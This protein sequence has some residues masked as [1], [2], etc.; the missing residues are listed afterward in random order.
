MLKV[1]TTCN[2]PIKISLKQE[3]FSENYP[4][5]DTK[6]TVKKPEEKNTYEAAV[7]APIPDDS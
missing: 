1:W 7:H 2:V 6:E 5:C 4:Q 3:H